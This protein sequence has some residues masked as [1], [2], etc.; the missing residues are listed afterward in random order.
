MEY[1]RKLHSVH[2]IKNQALTSDG[3]LYSQQKGESR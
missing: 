2:M 1:K 3:H